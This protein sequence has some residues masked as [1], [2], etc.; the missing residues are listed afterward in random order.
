MSYQDNFSLATA[1]SGFRGRVSMCVTEQAK[2]F[3]NDDRPEYKLLAQVAV[4]DNATITA[5]MVPLVAT[6]PAMTSNS[7]DGDI[8]SAVQA[9]WPVLGER[10]V[11]PPPP[12]APEV[13]AAPLP[14]G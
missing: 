11:P 3:V 4:A 9:M 5:Q 12:P 2:I 10:L 1:D 13:P 7:T 6:Q 14:G 8:L